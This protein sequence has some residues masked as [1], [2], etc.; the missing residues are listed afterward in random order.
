MV[1]ELVKK[2]LRNAHFKTVVLVIASFTIFLALSPF[3]YAT[4]PLNLTDFPTYLSD[5]LLITP[6]QG[7]LLA[8]LILAFLSLLPLVYL[9][10][11]RNGSVIIIV[12]MVITGFC[13]SIG[14]LPVWVLA[15]ITLLL[16]LGLA[17]KLTD[18]F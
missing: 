6:F 7:G 17:K 4:D 1:G 16:A 2:Y 10:R 15:V 12:G 8:T 3:T 9:S 18:M 14:W 11:S 13:A 5:Q